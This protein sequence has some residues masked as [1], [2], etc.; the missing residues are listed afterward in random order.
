MGRPLVAAGPDALELEHGVLM[1]VLTI[2][3]KTVALGYKG[4]AGDRR[5][6]SLS[7]HGA[8]VGFAPLHNAALAQCRSRAG[9]L[10]YGHEFDRDGRCYW[11]DQREA[12]VATVP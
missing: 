3:R 11:C 12:N 6:V 5:Y 4:L 2:N 7:D 1:K 8:R 10:R 9:R